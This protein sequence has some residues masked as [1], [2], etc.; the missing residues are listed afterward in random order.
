M[1]ETEFGMFDYIGNITH[2]AK[3][4]SE[5]PSGGIPTNR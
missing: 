3:T 5:G 2:H 4:Q 1:A